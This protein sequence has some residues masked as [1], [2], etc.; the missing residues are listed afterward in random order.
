MAKAED[1]DVFDTAR[2]A[3]MFDVD[4]ATVR[5][6]AESGRLVGKRL[7]NGKGSWVFSAK[8]VRE[9][10]DRDA[11]EHDPSKGGRPRGSK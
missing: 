4:T 9:F 2:V 1:D 10:K 8:S 3:K 5:R 11:R 6:W 7:A